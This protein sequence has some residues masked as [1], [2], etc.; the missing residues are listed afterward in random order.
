M[1]GILLN[2][3]V[4]RRLYVEKRMSSPKIA[5][6]FGVS[7]GTV[8]NY[9]RRYKIPIRTRSE[10]ATKYE[11]KPF[12]GD[13]RERAHLLGLR[14][15]DIYAKMN[16]KQICIK[17]TTTHLSQV[18]MIQKTFGK[19]GQVFIYS[20]IGSNK[21]KQWGVECGL[22]E[23]FR[24]LLKKPN[25]I[26]SWVL[27]NENTFYSFLAGY[28]DCEGT[29]DTRKTN[30]N[31]TR[32]GFR[33]RTSD[34]KILLQLK[35]RLEEF[36]YNPT[37]YLE[38]KRGTK[39]NIGKHNKDFFALCVLRKSETLSLA[40]KLLNLSRHFEKIRRMRLILKNGDKNW[41]EINTK[42]LN[43][44]TSIKMEH[45]DRVGDRVVRSH[46]RSNKKTKRI[47]CEENIYSVS[48]RFETKNT[49]DCERVRE[50]F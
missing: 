36:G 19:Y 49:R 1:S 23:S 21:K 24:F 43:L 44:R 7:D 26:P 4:L 34:K 28:M 16:S 10:A 22:N 30:K 37:F 15:G 31:N 5:K 29:W 40:Q 35:K 32:I 18:I 33:I 25:K 8:L 42:V 39:T 17:T 13:L 47:K 45:I 20:F 12:C 9:L 27:E 41:N 2:S 46:E 3:G 50:I 38:R 14:A 11:M 48:R 6:R